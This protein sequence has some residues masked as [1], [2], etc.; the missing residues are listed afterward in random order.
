LDGS[1][2]TLWCLPVTL[3]LAWLVRR[4]AAIVAAHLPEAG[5][6]HLRD[7]GVLRTSRPRWWITWWS[8]LVWSREPPHPGLP[9]PVEAR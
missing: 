9:R 2:L 4:A 6:L 7:Y 5:I 3:L 8:A 1:G